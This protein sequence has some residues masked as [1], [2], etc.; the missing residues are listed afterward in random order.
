MK[1]AV[2]ILGVAFA[3]ATAPL[4]PEA[5]AE[6]EYPWCAISSDVMGSQTCSF[7]RLDQ[8]RAFVTS[9]GFCQPNA[10]YIAP[11]GVRPARPAGS[12]R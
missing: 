2:K 12:S 9:T 7:A 11:A 4:A 3:L 5:R 6:V 8:C 10:R 1:S